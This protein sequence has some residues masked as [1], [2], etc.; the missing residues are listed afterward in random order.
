MIDNTPRIRGKETGS[1]DQNTIQERGNT[2][3]GKRQSS[4]LIV[5]VKQEKCQGLYQIDAEH[6]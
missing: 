4:R 5:H 6:I 1:K 3:K 2:E